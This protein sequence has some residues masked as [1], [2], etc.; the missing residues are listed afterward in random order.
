MYNESLCVASCANELIKA[1]GRLKEER[2]LETEIIFSDDGSTDGCGETVSRF[3]KDHPEIK[4]V[5]NEKNKGKGSAVRKAV[6]GS[7]GDF[8]IY[9]DCDLAYGTEV[10]FSAVDR[11]VSGSDDIIV[12]SRNLTGDGYD[13]Y[14]VLRRIASKAY[15]RFLSAL[16]G[17]DLSD[18]QCGFKAFRGDAARKIFSLSS[19]DG[20]AFDYEMILIADKLGMKIGEMPVRILTHKESKVH[21][22]KDS[23]SM[24]IEF[25][26]I[27][28]RISRSDFTK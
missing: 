14:G 1:I 24:L 12:G 19:C 25:I 21:L 4:T 22:V 23:I 13:G 11:L 3:A 7:S 8:V 6:A 20:F 5:K 16:G 26:R 17:L 2:K 28:N 18:S 15:I 27:K 10:F 9:T